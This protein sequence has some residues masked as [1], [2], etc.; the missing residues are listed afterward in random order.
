[1]LTGVTDAFGGT[2]TFTLNG[3]GNVTE[4]A[5]STGTVATYEYFPS[6]SR[7]KTVT[8]PD[9]S[10]YKFEYTTVGSTYY[11][12]TVKDA[13]DNILETHAYDSSGRATTSEKDGGGE[14]YTINYASTASGQTTVTDT[15]G[16]VTKYNF[17]KSLG[18][19]LITRLEG[20]CGCGSSGSET[21]TYT[22]DHRA[23]LVKKVDALLNQTT[24]TYDSSSNLKSVTDVPAAAEGDSLD[25]IAFNPVAS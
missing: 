10:K 9:S 11:L 12:A 14:K 22:Y 5:D 4:I 2:L 24:Y 17:D 20:Q 15:L 1:M 6:S 16:R 25:E 13:L 18:V 19:N 7:L 8:Y 23:N 21:T 3:S